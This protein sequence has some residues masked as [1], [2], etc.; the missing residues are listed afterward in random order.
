MSLLS[1]TQVN[2]LVWIPRFSAPLSIIGSAC[3][4][5]LLRSKLT[6]SYNRLIFALSVIDIATSFWWAVGALPVPAEFPI[7]GAHGNR[8]SCSTQAFMTIFGM[9]SILFYNSSLMVYFYLTICVGMTS[10][11][12]EKRIEPVLHSVSLLL[13]LMVSII[14]L[15]LGVFNWGGGFRCWVAPSPL[16]CDRFSAIVGECTRGEHATAFEWA[17]INVPLY[18][19]SVVFYMAVIRVYCQFRKTTRNARRSSMTNATANTG[20]QL[21]VQ[22]ILYGLFFANTCIWFVILSILD[23]AGKTHRIDRIY[24]II[25]LTNIFYP[26]QGFFNFFIYIRPRYLRIRRENASKSRG[27]ALCVIF[28]YPQ[29]EDTTTSSSLSSGRSRFISFLRRSSE[30]WRSDPSSEIAMGTSNR[31]ARNASMEQPSRERRTEQPI[32]ELTMVVT[33]N[34]QVGSDGASTELQS[35]E[36]LLTTSNEKVE[37]DGAIIPVVHNRY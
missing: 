20:R 5:H 8:A 18:V 28:R 23:A 14:G 35:P 16:G 10:N 24:P 12:F 33:S 25:V 13:P 3:L 15:A 1:E 37:T 2:A 19:S 29:D 34:G 6:N 17:F 31:Q 4:M 7:K 36:L 11:K 27:W 22:C 32:P 9:L 26:M 30:L 21:A